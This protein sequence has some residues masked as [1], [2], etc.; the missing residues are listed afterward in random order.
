MIK[1]LTAQPK[2][3]TTRVITKSEKI[4]SRAMNNSFTKMKNMPKTTYLD[5]ST[6]E[7][8][9]F[10]RRDSRTNKVVEVIQT[11]FPR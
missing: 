4:G 10:T 8:G 6:E 11:V 7:L 9:Y 5:F 3:A 2:L 1:L